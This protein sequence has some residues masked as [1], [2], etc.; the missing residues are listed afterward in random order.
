MLAKRY[1]IIINLLTYKDNVG[2]S[3]TNMIRKS[4]VLAM[5]ASRLHNIICHLE[6][7]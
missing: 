5:S 6:M 3:W 1:I 4:T 7:L 2:Y